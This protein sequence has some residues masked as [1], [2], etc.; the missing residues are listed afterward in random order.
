MSKRALA[1]RWNRLYAVIARFGRDSG[2]LVRLR[3][4]ADDLRVKGRH[5]GTEAFWNHLCIVL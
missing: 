3:R 1:D 5:G 2:P 4:R